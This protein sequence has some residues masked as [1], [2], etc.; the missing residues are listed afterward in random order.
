MAEIPGLEYLRNIAGED[1]RIAQG[2]LA[3]NGNDELSAATTLW[4]V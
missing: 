1:E 2:M 3:G 4:S